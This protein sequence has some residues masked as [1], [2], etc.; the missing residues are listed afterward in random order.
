M[1]T[2]GGRPHLLAISQHSDQRASD[3]VQYSTAAVSPLLSS[4]FPGMI[5]QLIATAA[6]RTTVI[7]NSECA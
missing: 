7:L 3:A 5:S 2:D 4:S 6:Y 1:G